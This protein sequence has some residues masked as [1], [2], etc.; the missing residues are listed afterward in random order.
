MPRQ[1]QDVVEV[2]Q[3]REHPNLRISDFGTRR[4]HSFLWQ[5]W[6]VEA[7]KEGIGPSFTDPVTCYWQ[8]DNDLER[9][10]PMRTSCRWWPRRLPATTASLRPRPYKVLQDWNQLYGGNLLIVLPDAFGTPRFSGMRPTGWAD[11]TGFRPDSAPP[12]RGRRE[13]H[14]LVEEDGPRPTGGSS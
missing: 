1:G 13:D 14:R 5:R 2:E 8:W 6:C 11:W 12:H 7:L 3:L 10:A 4:R 9:L